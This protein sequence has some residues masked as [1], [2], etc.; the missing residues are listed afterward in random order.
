VAD[1]GAAGRGARFDALALEQADPLRRRLQRMLGDRQTAEDLCQE[2]L[3]RAWA[4]APRDAPDDHLR[5][6]LHRTATNLGLDELRRRRVRRPA[7]LDEL[8]DAGPV[9][10]P[11]A[12]LHVREA[13]G[14]LTAHERLLLLLRFEAGLSH[15]EIAALLAVREAA[16]RK[17][18]SRARRAFAAAMRAT[19]ERDAPRVAL[20]VADGA[21][22]SCERWLGEAGAEVHVL[23]PAAPGLT[24]AGADA[25]ALTG[26]THD[27]HPRLYGEA[28]SPAVQ[29][30]DLERDRR[31]LRLVRQALLDDVP[32][33]GVCRGAQLLNV[34]LGG[35]LWQDLGAT[36]VPH[37]TDEPHAIRT[38]EGSPLREIIGRGAAVG[39][40]HHQAVRR[41]GRGVRP[42]AISADGVVEAVDVPSRRFALGV[43]WHP[44]SPASPVAGPLLAEALVQAA[45]R[46]YAPSAGGVASAKKRR[47]ASVASGPDGSV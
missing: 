19:A 34:A 32:I 5:A 7:P 23:D 17:R 16:V 39:G 31:D 2:A 8:P 27:L 6:W 26:S 12:A 30:A 11:D 33:V 28:C 10:D 18:L 43:Q 21:P 35:S 9:A 3:A 20:L 45:S 15:R 29:H 40:A 47:M 4:S 24:L 22:D 25:F 46:R 42:T 1:R 14:R 38:G 41:L 36:R 13:L 37:P 44:E